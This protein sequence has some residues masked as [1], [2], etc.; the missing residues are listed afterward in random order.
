ML[1]PAALRCLAAAASG[2][3]VLSLLAGAAVFVMRRMAGA[4]TTPLE[5]AVLIAAGLAAAAAA[6]ASRLALAAAS[7]GR[8]AGWTAAALA[9]GPAVPLIGL[10]AALTLPGSDRVALVLFWLV[11]VAEE[12]CS[13]GRVLTRRGAAPW[14][15]VPGVRLTQQLA[16]FVAADGAETLAGRLRLDFSPDQ[17]TLAAHVAFCPP[18]ARLPQ[19]DVCQVRGPAVRLKMGQLLPHGVRIEARLAQD[20]PAVVELEFTAS[21]PADSPPPTPPA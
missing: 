4:L 21:L 19:F 14:A 8:A 9:L 5:P 17:R 11:L 20:G 12:G 7:V 10:G 16:R 18:F 15:P 1:P 13:L 2:V 6:L 3:L